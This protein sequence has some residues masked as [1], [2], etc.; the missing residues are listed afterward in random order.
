[1]LEGEADALVVTAGEIAGGVDPGVQI[2]RAAE[3]LSG[4][5]SGTFGHMV[6]KDDGQFVSSVEVPQEAEEFGDVG[7]AVFVEAVEPDQWVEQEHFGCEGNE[8]LVEGVTVALEVEAQAGGSDDL[9]VQTSQREPSMAADLLDAIAHVVQ[10]ILGEV[11]DDGPGSIDGEVLEAGGAGGDGDG[12][13]QAQP[14]FTGFRRPPDHA[15]GGSAPDILDQPPGVVG[16]LLDGV[17]GK[18]GQAGHGASTLRASMTSP[19][20]TAFAPVFTTCSRAFRARRSMARR[21]P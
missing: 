14:G 16:L 11:D 9:E 3:G 6:H 7:G 18:R 1:M 17:D 4:I 8:G 21:L 15:D 20:E 19:A 5:L 10:R 2:S 13:I 12:Q